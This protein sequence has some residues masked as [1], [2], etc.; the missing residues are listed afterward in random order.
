M[1]IEQC[2]GSLELQV[3]RRKICVVH[4]LFSIR[5]ITSLLVATVNKN[6]FPVKAT[7]PESPIWFQ[8]TVLKVFLCFCKVDSFHKQL[9][10]LHPE[11]RFN[12]PQR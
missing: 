12:I 7:D 2:V 10:D 8:Q 1:L 4:V 9:V 6:T 3:N 11:F 5:A